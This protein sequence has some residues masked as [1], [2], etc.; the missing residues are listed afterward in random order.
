MGFRLRGLWGVWA[1][2]V[3]FVHVRFVRRAEWV[4]LFESEGVRVNRYR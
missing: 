1:L 2:N 4:G 3:R